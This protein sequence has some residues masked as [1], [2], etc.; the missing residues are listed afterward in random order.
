MFADRGSIAIGQLVQQR[1]GVTGKPVRLA[2]PPS[3]LTGRDELL[4]EL[5]ARLAKGDEVGPRTV[6]L[7][8]MGGV[9]KTSVAMAYGRRHLGE[10]GVAWRFTADDLTVLDAEFSELAAQFG[11]RDLADTRNPV[12]CTGCSP[13]SQRNGYWC[14]TTCQTGQRL[15]D[16]CH[17]LGL[18]GF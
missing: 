7:W 5:D 2:D 15:N 11:V 10:V 12:T 6:A 1:P 18:D 4:A 14:S 8:G 17:P 9:G 16:S 3:L 13:H